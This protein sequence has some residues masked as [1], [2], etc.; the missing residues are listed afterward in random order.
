[1]Q[2]SGVWLARSHRHERFEYAAHCDSPHTYTKLAKL[3][4]GSLEKNVDLT[5]LPWLPA[6]ARIQIHKS[7][8]DI[9]PRL[10]NLQ[11]E[12]ERVWRQALG[13]ADEAIPQPD[14]EASQP[15]GPKNLEALR[16][17]Y[18]L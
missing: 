7:L 11:Q 1:M 2:N 3:T 16:D 4:Y 9:D 15:I 12:S 13:F 8:R 18:A 17:K 6:G 10:A 14:A 5:K